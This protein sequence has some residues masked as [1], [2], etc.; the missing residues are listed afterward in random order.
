M[1]DH[2]GKDLDKG[3][4]GGSA[5][6]DNIDIA[7]QLTPRGHDKLTLAPTHV[8]FR[9]DATS[10]TLSLV[11]STSPR[12]AHIQDTWENTTDPATEFRPTRFMEKISRLVESTPNLSKTEVLDLVTGR[13]EY[14]RK[15]LAI[16]IAEGYIEDARGMHNKALL[17]ELKPYR[18]GTDPM[19]SDRTEDTG[20]DTP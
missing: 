14:K 8:R 13:A 5:K 2:T 1:L 16:L 3:A 9:D 10:H 20:D 6:T 18:E 17:A 12:L 7:Y 15:A 11:R 4:R 19:A